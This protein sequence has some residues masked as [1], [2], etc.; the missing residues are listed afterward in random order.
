[1]TRV[2]LLLAFLVGCSGWGNGT[3]TGNPKATETGNPKVPARLAPGGWSSAPAE[4]SVGAGG[5]IEVH[6][7]WLW[8]EAMTFTR[9]DAC[10]GEVEE[11]R[12]DLD[13][14]V[15]DLIGGAALTIELPATEYCGLSVEIDAPGEAPPGAPPELDATALVIEGALQD[16][17]PF[18]V[19]SDEGASWRLDGSYDL[20]RKAHALA[21]GVDVARWFEGIDLE[22]LPLDDGV[23]VLDDESDTSALSAFED[24]FDA[25]PALFL[26]SNDN[27]ALDPA[28]TDAPVATPTD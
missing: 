15:L 24:N 22:S 5:A 21:L 12:P 26:D 11:E 23:L 9:G 20:T 17:T 28:E 25:S 2:H 13:E 3:E 1:M 6:G 10:V 14:I 4:V 19:L 16:G 18:R 8:V 27:G 7:A